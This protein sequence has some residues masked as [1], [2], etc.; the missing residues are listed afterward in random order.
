[1]K[2]IDDYEE[3]RL[4][5]DSYDLKFIF[6]CLKKLIVNED[7]NMNEFYN[8]NKGLIIPVMDK[9]REAL[10]KVNKVEKMLFS[11]ECNNYCFEEC[12]FYYTKIMID[13][14]YEEAITLLFYLKIKKFKDECDIIRKNKI[15]KGLQEY[16]GNHKAWLDFRN[17]TVDNV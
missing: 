10:P 5:Y 8:T 7:E 15:V 17:I 6:E 4:T 13:L 2:C 11:S 12:I 9:F 14:T 3:F 1:M 16:I